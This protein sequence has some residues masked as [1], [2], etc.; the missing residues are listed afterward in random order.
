MRPNLDKE[1]KQAWVGFA[2]VLFLGGLGAW[3]I[4]DGGLVAQER[5]EAEAAYLNRIGKT[6]MIDQ[7]EKSEAAIRDLESSIQELKKTTGIDLVPPFVVPESVR[8]EGYYFRVVFDTVRDDLQVKAGGIE[9]GQLGFVQLGDAPPP[10][11]DA[12]YWLSMLQLVS[13]TL[14]LCVEA[15]GG[16]LQ[17]ISISGVEL[18]KRIQTGPT[19]RPP[20]LQEYPFTL[21]VK[22]SL[23]SIS[24]LLLQLSADR[25]TPG[26]QDG[27]LLSWLGSVGDKVRQV[28][29]FQGVARNDVDEPVG[30]LIV[31]GYEITSA[32]RSEV[33]QI[34]QLDATFQLAGMKYLTYEERGEKPRIRSA[35]VQGNRSATPRAA[36]P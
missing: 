5:S 29:G 6:R 17:E 32:N 27:A 19:S 16:P 7:V 28:P 8:D 20:L 26:N 25:N 4:W 9:L 34:T 31:R 12:Q 15:P 22:G 33:D 35:P 21:R 1:K 23:E 36:R 3:W 10:D 24:W 11:A 2:V 13:K 30:P 18:N 14:Y